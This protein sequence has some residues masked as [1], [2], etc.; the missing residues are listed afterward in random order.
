VLGESG[1]LGVVVQRGRSLLDPVVYLSPLRLANAVTKALLALAQSRDIVDGSRSSGVVGHHLGDGC[2]G[3][4][5][6]FLSDLERE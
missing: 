1:V 3:A 5:L 6:H 2:M 4:G